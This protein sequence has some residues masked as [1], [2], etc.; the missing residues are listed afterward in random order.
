[1]SEIMAG[2]GRRS[3]S[4]RHGAQFSPVEADARTTR[5]WRGA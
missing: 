5:D 3:P 2:R 4:D 1:M